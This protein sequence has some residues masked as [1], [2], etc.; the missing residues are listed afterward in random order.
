MIAPELAGRLGLH[1]AG[2]EWRGACPVCG[3]P[4]A[5]ALADGRNGRPVA[6]CANCQ[7]RHGIAAILVGAEGALPRSAAALPGEDRAAATGRRTERAKVLWAGAGP[8][9]GS[10]AETYLRS[11]RIGHVAA[12]PALRFRAD[13]PHPAGGRLPALLARI[14]GSGGEMMALHRTYLRRDGGGKADVEPARASLGLVRGGAVRLDPAAPEL[15]VGEGI[16]SAAAAGRLTGLPCWAAVS[17]GNLAGSMLL[18]PGVRSVVIAVDRDAP[19]ERAAREAA[20]RW[21]REGRRVRLMV[22]DRAGADM[23]DVLMERRHAT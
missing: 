17:A 10:I 4:A 11:R 2:R 7:D 14:D 20:W 19:G 22:P 18:P 21:Q 5:F 6:W 8:V 1:R 9:P 3:Y 15:V 16:E 12:S 23:A 13:T